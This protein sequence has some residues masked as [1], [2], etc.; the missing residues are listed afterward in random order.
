MTAVLIN[1]GGSLSKESDHWQYIHSGTQH[2]HFSRELSSLIAAKQG[3][4][5]QLV[6]A[7]L[8]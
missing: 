8:Q 3:Q 4:R 6:I 1:I 7:T 2:P 5:I